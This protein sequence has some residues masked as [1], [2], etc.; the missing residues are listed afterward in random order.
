VTSPEDRARYDYILAK[1]YAQAG[2]HDHSLEFLRKAMEDGYK[3]MKNA[4]TDPEFADLRKDTRFADLMKQKPPA[5][6][7]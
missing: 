3:D 5:I 4:Y 6:P 7:E 2:D 1:I